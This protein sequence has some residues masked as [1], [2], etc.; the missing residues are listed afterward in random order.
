MISGPSRF[1]CSIDLLSA[2]ISSLVTPIKGVPTVN[3]SPVSKCRESSRV[4]RTHNNWRLITS[5][6]TFLGNTYNCDLFVF[7]PE[8]AI[9]K[10]PL[11]E[12]KI[13]KFCLGCLIISDS[14]ILLDN[15]GF[16]KC[17][18]WM[19]KWRLRNE[20]RNSILMTRHY[21]DLGSA[22]AWWEICF[23]QSEALTRS[24]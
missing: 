6:C 23:N 2:I 8:F 24:G 11:P 22:S 19:T 5:A 3:K 20:S 9:L 14:E 16:L 15:A 12:E 21:P 10:I 1:P 13:N 18:A 7:G 17:Q 4:K